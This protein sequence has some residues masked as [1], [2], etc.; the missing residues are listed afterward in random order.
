M[1]RVNWAQPKVALAVPFLPPRSSG[2]GEVRRE[3]ALWR[4]GLREPGPRSETAYGLHRRVVASFAPSH[5]SS[6]YD[7]HRPRRRLVGMGLHHP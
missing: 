1:C 6:L 7:V 5:H 4:A 3:P 2:R